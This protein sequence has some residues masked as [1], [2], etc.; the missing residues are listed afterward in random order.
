MPFWGS[1]V[2]TSYYVQYTID[3]MLV[4]NLFYL[5]TALVTSAF[6][7]AQ[8]DGWH[9]DYV[10]TLMNAQLD[11][12]VFPN[13]QSDHMHKIIGGSR[14]A[15]YYNF[16]DYQSAKCSSLRVQADKSNYW[17][18]SKSLHLSFMSLNADLCQTFI[19]S[20]RMLM[21]P[22]CI[23]L[24]LPRAGSITSSLEVP[25]MRQLSHSPKAFV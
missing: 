7:V 21:A 2:S 9:I 17:M 25:K 22:T 3:D 8:D 15:A 5:I 24:Y 20:A 18:P 4:N 14:M 10:Y 13:G 6:V 12:I 11:P 19:S 23:R 16:E 1:F